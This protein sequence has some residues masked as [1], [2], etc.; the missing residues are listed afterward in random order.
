[1]AS[2]LAM[3]GCNAILGID[4]LSL[5]DAGVTGDVTADV[6]VCYGT[7]VH[8]CFPVAPAGPLMLSGT[9]DTG[10]DQRCSTGPVCAIG[11]DS[12]VIGA[13]T[14]SGTRPLVL[15]ALTNLTVSDKLEAT[16]TPNRL[17][18]G[19]N[20]TMCSSSGPAASAATSGGGAGGSFGT[21]GAA[22]G[23]GAAAGGGAAG[24]PG[25]TQTPMA[26]RGGCAGGAGAGAGGNGGNGGGAISLYAGVKILIN[27]DVRVSGA[28]GTAGTAGNGGGGGGGSGGMIVLEA[29]EI[30]IA[31]DV[32]AN[33]GGGGEGA[34]TA[35]SGT[36][37]TESNNF[38]DTA[39]GGGGT[40]GGDGGDGFALV[41][42]AEGGKTAGMGG[43]GGGGGG[44]G[45]IWV[46]GVVTGT[47][48]SPAAIQR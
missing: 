10:A 34:S 2:A 46:H 25:V 18:P 29:P 1:M 43:G 27:E 14:V 23:R 39:N 3:T 20:S 4:D 47:R 22:G 8:A 9:L 13:L 31:N 42:P 26:L 7:L 38:D 17:G 30:T 41:T 15:V 32:F 37:G 44:G 28:G 48:I 19:A 45:V 36:N 40:S 12:I 21:S 16:S 5:R 24:T 11:A 35:A 33:G 6:G